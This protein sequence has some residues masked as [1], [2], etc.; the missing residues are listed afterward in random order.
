MSNAVSA[1]EGAAFTGIATVTEDG[2]HGM[3]TLRGDL[4]AAK[5]KSAAKAAAGVAIPQAGQAA[6]AGTG[7]IAWMSPDEVLILCDYARVDETLAKLQKAVAKDHAL[8]VDVSDA[9]AVFTVSGDHARDVLAKLC[10]V[11]LSPAAFP[12]GSFRR[13]RMAQVPAAFW[14]DQAGVFHVICFR[15]V[16]QYVFDLLCVAAQ[17]GSEVG[18]NAG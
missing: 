4:S 8:A 14:L 2:L 6:F 1:L 3:I 18:L 11:D 13:T 17:T 12:A 10:P 15:S 16:A 5:V 9:R 7:G